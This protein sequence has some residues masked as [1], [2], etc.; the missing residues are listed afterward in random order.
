MNTLT[1]DFFLKN[2]VDSTKVYQIRRFLLNKRLRMLLGIQ[3]ILSVKIMERT[4]WISRLHFL[5]AKG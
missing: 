1:N 4:S 5:M 2:Y 3:I